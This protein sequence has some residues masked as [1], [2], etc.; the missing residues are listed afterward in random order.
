MA[1]ENESGQHEV[2]GN[3]INIESRIK[4]KRKFVDP[5]QHEVKKQAY[6]V[7]CSSTRQQEVISPVNFQLTEK[8][9][10]IEQLEAQL[11]GTLFQ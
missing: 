4:R 8:D 10:I 6:D 1:T 11:K 5:V 7:T 9:K 3:D 2:H